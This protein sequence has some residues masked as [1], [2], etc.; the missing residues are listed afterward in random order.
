MFEIDLEDLT[1]GELELIGD[2]LDID[3]TTIGTSWKPTDWREAM[4]LTRAYVWIQRRRED[5]SVTLESISEL[6]LRE[7]NAMME[8]D[9]V[10]PARAG[11]AQAPTSGT[12]R[13]SRTSTGSRRRTSGV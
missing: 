5:P 7:F 10:P 2:A 13:S 4:R 6:K 11:E 3:P 1:L 8:G 9:A 12:S